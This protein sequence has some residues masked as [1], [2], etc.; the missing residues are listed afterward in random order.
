MNVIFLGP[1]GAGKGTQAKLIED[2]YELKQLS[3]GDMLRSAVAAGTEVGR[4]AK[5]FMDQGALVP[6]EV[7]VD[8]VL[9]AIDQMRGTKGI[10]LDGF[11]TV[12]QAKH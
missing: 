2:R 1:P 10:I 6:D 7:V 12:P 3:S 4:K 8:V 9:E 11:R 5:S